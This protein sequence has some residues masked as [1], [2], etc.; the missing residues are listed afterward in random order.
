MFRFLVRRA[1][2]ALV[3]LLII[4]AI[5]FVLFYV[6]PRD[7]A[8]VACGK[9][10]TP[11][12]LALVTAQPGHRPPAARAVLALAAASSSAGDYTASGTAPRPASATPSHNREPVLG[13]IIDRFP[14]TL[15]LALGSAG[16][17]PALR[18]GHRHARRLAAGQR[19]S[20][21]CFSSASL[22]A[23]SMQIYFV[24]AVAMYFLVYQ[25][26]ILGQPK[27]VPFTRIR[28]AG[29]RACCCRGA[30]CRSSSP[31]NY[32]RMAR[33]AM[34]EQL[35]GGLRPHGPR[36][37]HVQPYGLLPVR[38]ARRADPDRHHL[39]H[40]PRHRCSAARSSPRRPSPC[41]HRARCR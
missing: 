20:T 31:R 33:S 21:R 32:T 37:G 12:T 39:R 41:R 1:L 35:A 15:S 16:R 9:V 18:C 13:T 10:C 6:A 25:W 29:S 7:P 28:P 14:T 38:L 23:R 8:R 26:H 24:G 34:V 3:I 11:E 5:T 22:V 2:G 40:R 4:S 36:Q 19:W 27:Y 17:L 30:C